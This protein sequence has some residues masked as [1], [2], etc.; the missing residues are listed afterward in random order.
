MCGRLVAAPLVAVVIGS[1]ADVR[2]LGTSATELYV[3]DRNCM[4][5]VSEIG[6]VFSRG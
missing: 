3:F 6:V 5:P 2:D 1:K 4:T